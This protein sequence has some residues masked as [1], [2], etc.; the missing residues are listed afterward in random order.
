MT[1][2]AAREAILARIRQ[3]L[4]A[5]PPPLAVTSG[6]AVTSIPRRYATRAPAGTDVVALFAERAG[7]YRA[8][9]QR[10]AAGDLPAAVAA[11]LRGRSVGSVAVPDGLPAG[12]LTGLDRDVAVTVD[13]PPLSL[14][15][16]DGTDAV[17]TGAALAIAETG[18]VI[19]DAGPDQGRRALSL[20]VDFHVCVLGVGQIVGTVVEA[21]ARVPADRPQ[22]WISGP[23]ATSDIELN[24]VEGVHGP[25]NLHILITG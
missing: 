21:V 11:A 10:V 23:S 12:W 1:G 3:A 9:V 16:L 15:Q 22:T 20:L 7:E 2:G 24:R 8:T 4:A 6:P 25:R 18:T 17:L 13:A 19:L 5:A 14:R